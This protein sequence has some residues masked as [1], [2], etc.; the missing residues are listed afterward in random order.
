MAKAEDGPCEIDSVRSHDCWLAVKFHIALEA[1]GHMSSMHSS[2]N[3]YRSCRLPRR[4]DWEGS[5]SYVTS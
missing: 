3:T 2:W 5:T 4:P 1:D